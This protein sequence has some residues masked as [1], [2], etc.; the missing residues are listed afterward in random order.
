MQGALVSALERVE[1][2]R[3]VYLSFLTFPGQ[4]LFPRNEN[5]K[6]LHGTYPLDI[7]TVCLEK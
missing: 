2:V 4:F 1:W 6:K 3:W 7:D 5:L